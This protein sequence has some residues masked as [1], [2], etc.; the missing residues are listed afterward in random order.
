MRGKAHLGK[1]L[2]ALIPTDIETVPAVTGEAIQELEVAIITANPFQPRINFDDAAF[3]DLKRSIREKGVIQPVLVRPMGDGNF[4]LVAGERRLRATI[5]LGIKKIPAFVK[6][7]TSDEEMLEIALIENVQ[8]EQLNPIELGKGYQQLIDECG[9][10]Q[11][12][13]AKKI[14]KDRTTVSNVIRL[15]K[16]PSKIQDSL[17]KGSLREGHARA[18]LSVADEK[19]QE[20]IWKKAV[21]ENLSVRSVEQLARKAQEKVKSKSPEKT[22]QQ[23]KSAYNNRIESKLREKFGT[24]VKLRTKKEGGSIEIVYYS[25]EDLERLMDILDQIKF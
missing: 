10:T 13:V 24:Q 22:A 7:I 9:L 18:L 11:E 23:R 25:S 5:D 1:G 8:R 14:G 21:N 19:E 15:L 17:Q 16:L 12:E 6:E 2:H 4:Q 3:E 20:K